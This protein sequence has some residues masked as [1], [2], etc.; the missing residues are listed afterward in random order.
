M[1]KIAELSQKL[2]NEIRLTK[3]LIE[4]LRGNQILSAKARILYFSD[5]DLAPIMDTLKK[6]KEGGKAILDHLED[7]PAK[8]DFFNLS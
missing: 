1:V 3:G 8:N 6:I 4:S 7:G 2:R 5:A